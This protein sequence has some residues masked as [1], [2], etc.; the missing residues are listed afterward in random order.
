[1]GLWLLSQTHNWEETPVQFSRSVVST[2]LQPH[3]LQHTGFPY[4][5]PIPGVYSDSC[6]LS[7]WC[8]L[9]IFS[10]IPFSSQ[11]QSFSASVS[12]Q[13]S[14]FFTSGGQSIGV[15]ASASVLLK[16]VQ[17][18]FPL[19]LTGWI[20]LQ[21]KAL[22]RVFFKTTVQKHKFFSVQLSLYMTFFIHD[23]Y[24]MCSAFFIHYFLYT[25]LF[26]TW[27]IHPY[28][29]TGKTI[30]LAGRTFVGKVISAF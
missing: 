29:T 27:H 8:H 7:Q 28:M 10:V 16:N 4:L 6:P 20:S 21:S 15:S 19:G 2:S 13:M 17:D 1:M 18:W 24:I 14:Q 22:S 26:Y 9:T 12:F 11:F 3:E 23:I 25:W 5:S 30:A